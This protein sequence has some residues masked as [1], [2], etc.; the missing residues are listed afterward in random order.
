MH[1]VPGRREGV[2]SPPGFALGLLLGFDLLLG[3]LLQE[4]AREERREE[5]EEVS[6][7]QNTPQETAAEE[8]VEEEEGNA[9]A[10]GG[11]VEFGDV[12]APRGPVARHV[13]AD[14]TGPEG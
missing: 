2:R 3:E 14:F 11:V 4:W 7:A 10:D 1:V 9:L 8:E 6:P 5:Q 12:A 13:L